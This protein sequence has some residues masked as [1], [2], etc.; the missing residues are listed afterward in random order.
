G[1]FSPIWLTVE[2]PIPAEGATAESL[3]QAVRT[4]WKRRLDRP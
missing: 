4:I 3:Q 1:A 2:P